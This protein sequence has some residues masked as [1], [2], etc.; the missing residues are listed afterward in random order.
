MKSYIENDRR[1][2]RNYVYKKCV[3]S[4]TLDRLVTNCFKLDYMTNLDTTVPLS[5]SRYDIA[6]GNLVWTRWN[7]FFFFLI[8]NSWKF[9]SLLFSFFSTEFIEIREMDSFEVHA[10]THLRQWIMIDSGYQRNI[11]ALHRYR[12]LLTWFH[13]Q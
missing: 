10:M 1:Q 12:Q 2:I 3:L 11:W 7:F 9:P 5:R 4:N 13:L 6:N 8:R